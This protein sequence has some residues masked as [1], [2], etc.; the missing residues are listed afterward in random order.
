MKL[1]S[2]PCVMQEV[3]KKPSDSILLWR[4]CE[5][6][7]ICR[8]AFPL[9]SRNV[10]GLQGSDSIWSVVLTSPFTFRAIRVNE[11][12]KGTMSWPESEVSE[13]ESEEGRGGMDSIV[14]P[15]VSSTLIS[16]WSGF[17]RITEIGVLM[18][19][20]SIERTSEEGAFTGS[21]SHRCPSNL[22]SMRIVNSVS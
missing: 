20:P 16:M 6:S 14:V 13:R 18:I 19:L 11:S 2:V 8:Y 21:N 10:Y 4:V 3:S 7:L 9:M 22:L 15:T 1:I 12:C 5:S 17:P